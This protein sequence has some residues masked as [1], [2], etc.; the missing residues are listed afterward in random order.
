MI[1]PNHY[2]IIEVPVSVVGEAAG[3]VMSTN[4][5]GNNN[6]IGGLWVN[7][8]STDSVVV[9]RTLTEADGYFSYVG[10]VPGNY[11]ARIDGNQLSN[12]NMDADP[13]KFTIKRMI[14]GDIVDGLKFIVNGKNSR[15]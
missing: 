13:I 9:A 4:L 10:L 14:E 5:A 15:R 2:K 11:I 3:Y 12:I 8:Y 6:G 1:E 7:F